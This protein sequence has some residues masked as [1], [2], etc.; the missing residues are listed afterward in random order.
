MTFADWPTGFDGGIPLEKRTPRARPAKIGYVADVDFRPFVNELGHRHAM[1][2]I[3]GRFDGRLETDVHVA[4][5]QIGGDDGISVL[6]QT[7]R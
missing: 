4:Q 2:I 5:V 6:V 1:R 3:R 7:R